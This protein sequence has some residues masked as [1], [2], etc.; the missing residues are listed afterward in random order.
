M[1]S[2]MA[3]KKPGPLPRP[4]W[5]VADSQESTNLGLTLDSLPMPFGS[6]SALIDSDI[7]F[8]MDETDGPDGLALESHLA[9]LSVKSSP[10]AVTERRYD[11]TT[12]RQPSSPVFRAT[13]P[14]SYEAPARLSTAPLMNDAH[15]SASCSVF[16]VP[17]GLSTTVPRRQ[18]PRANTDVAEAAFCILGSSHEHIQ[19]TDLVKKIPR[20]DDGLK[21]GVRPILAEGAMGGTYFLRDRS[22]GIQL[23][24][25]PNDEEPFAPNNPHRSDNMWNPYKGRIIPGFGM[26]REVA[27]FALDGGFA[28]VPPTAMAKVMARED[29]SFSFPRHVTSGS[30]SRSSNSVGTTYKLGSVQSY[31]RAE[32]SSDDMGSSRFHKGDVM[33]IAVLDI[34]LC[35]LDRHAGNVLV[36]KTSP[37]QVRVLPSPRSSVLMPSSPRELMGC[38]MDCNSGYDDDWGLGL[39]L[40]CD[41][42]YSIPTN[43]PEVARGSRATSAPAAFD[44]SKVAVL[45]QE[46]QHT[47]PVTPATAAMRLVPID[48]GYCLPHCLAMSEVNFSWL[49]YQQ[50]CG[51][52]PSDMRQYIDSLDVDADCQLLDSL[53]GTA[54]PLSSKLTLRA[55][56]YLLQVGVAHGLS[57]HDIGLLMTADAALRGDSALQVA[58]KNAIQETLSVGALGSP[59][60]PHNTPDRSHAMGRNTGAGGPASPTSEDTLA[61]LNG[62]SPMRRTLTLGDMVDAGGSVHGSPSVAARHSQQGPAPL[63]DECLLAATCVP[64]RKLFRTMHVHITLLVRSQ[65]DAV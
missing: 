20:A 5:G 34:R 51:T 56:T 32:C 4:M 47:A 10:D 23:V 31:C 53:L 36:A 22:K 3:E 59:R 62:P 37:Y 1:S 54:I 52:I 44:A 21:A 61:T 60:V 65:H 13:S 28:G 25:K 16:T 12:H 48:H 58:I 49:H 8:V 7:P 33:R 55:C 40:N 45:L 50:T 46:K 38:A 43:S 11:H 2:T 57:L 29:D 14:T 41:R 35:N 17:Q 6:F 24:F 42:D 27:A 39:D 15:A 18:R 63:T 9:V 19:E 30:T 26:Y 64:D